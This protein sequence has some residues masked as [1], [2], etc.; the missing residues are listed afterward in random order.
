LGIYQYV[1]N[2][3]K[4]TT[5]H[6]SFFIALHSIFATWYRCCAI[7]PLHYIGE[8]HRARSLAIQAEITAAQAEV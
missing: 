1:R 6:H 8:Y 4:I 5:D 3:S 2:K 7:I